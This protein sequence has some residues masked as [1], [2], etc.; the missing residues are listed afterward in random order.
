MVID[1]INNFSFL[2]LFFH[3][4]LNCVFQEQLSCLSPSFCFGVLWLLIATNCIKGFFQLG[5]YFSL[6]PGRH[7]FNRLNVGFFSII[8]DNNLIKLLSPNTFNTFADGK[9]LKVMQL[10]SNLKFIFPLLFYFYYKRIYLA[11][12]NK[13][14]QA[15]FFAK[16]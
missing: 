10:L 9:P 11:V 6:S 8:S 15:T 5:H 4:F 14:P 16:L 13:F 1:F 12:K 3:A 7:F 2:K